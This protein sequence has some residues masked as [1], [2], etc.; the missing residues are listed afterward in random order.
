M[1][2][3]TQLPPVPRRWARG[4]SLPPPVIEAWASK[5]KQSPQ[6]RLSVL[7]P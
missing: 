1:A 3:F 5:L 4:A 6:V 2:S 7:T